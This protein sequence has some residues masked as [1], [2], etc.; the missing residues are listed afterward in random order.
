M[1]FGKSRCAT[2]KHLLLARPQPLA[3]PERTHITPDTPQRSTCL[4][5][6]VYQTTETILPPTPA[7]IGD[8]KDALLGNYDQTHMKRKRADSQALDEDSFGGLG[9]KL[10][11]FDGAAFWASI[12]DGFDR[13]QEDALLPMKDSICKLQLRHEQLNEKQTEQ[14]EQLS[15]IKEAVRK[16][17]QTLRT[18]TEKH[19][20]DI[21]ASTQTCTHRFQGQSQQVTN[22]STRQNTLAGTVDSHITQLPAL[23]E[24]STATATSVGTIRNTVNRETAKLHTQLR[25]HKCSVTNQVRQM[26]ELLKGQIAEDKKEFKEQVTKLSKEAKE[27][28]I[29]L[30]TMIKTSED[31][32]G[33]K[34]EK[35]DTDLAST[36]GRMD[37]K[38]AQSSPD[39]DALTANFSRYDD[40]LNYTTKEHLERYVLAQQNT[41]NLG[42]SQEALSKIVDGIQLS[43]ERVQQITDKFKTDITSYQDRHDVITSQHTRDISDLKSRLQPFEEKVAMKLHPPSPLAARFV[44]QSPAGLEAMS[45]ASGDSPGN[46]VSIITYLIERSA[47][48]DRYVKNHEKGLSNTNERF[49]SNKKRMADLHKKVTSLESSN[50]AIFAKHAASEQKIAEVERQHASDQETNKNRINELLHTMKVMAD[51]MGTM[52]KAQQAL[53]PNTA[54]TTNRNETSSCTKLEHLHQRVDAVEGQI[55]GNKTIADAKFVKSERLLEECTRFIRSGAA[56]TEELRQDMENRFETAISAT[57]EVLRRSH[58][59]S[60]QHQTAL[61]QQLDIGYNEA[62]NKLHEATAFTDKRVDETMAKILATEEVSLMALT[63]RVNDIESVQKASNE[64]HASTQQQVSKVQS[65]TLD[66]GQMKTLRSDL[67]ICVQ[68]LEDRID[69]MEAAQKPSPSMEQPSSWMEQPSSSTGE[70][71]KVLRYDVDTL[72]QNRQMKEIDYANMRRNF[73]SLSKSVQVCAKGAQLIALDTRLREYLKSVISDMLEDFAQQSLVANQ[74]CH[75]RM[76]GTKAIIDRVEQ[77]HNQLSARLPCALRH[78]SAVHLC[79][80]NPNNLIMPPPLPFQAFQLSTHTRK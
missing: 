2:P 30:E 36:L 70:E 1:E 23:E 76:E 77:A 53:V 52:Q 5:D 51:N 54:Q 57:E 71:F 62:V 14:E 6:N 78:P 38:I 65:L 24:S 21:A 69:N 25:N 29:A 64:S 33:R 72:M 44:P 47:R 61:L 56:N 59:T 60:K 75:D 79:T 20:S 42:K 22:L 26:E 68:A 18:D 16:D 32:Q 15:T 17:V 31:S 74:R 9:R 12:G 66:P 50:K 49:E 67:G 39:T 35:L 43:L 58:A 19:T 55:E 11:R 40:R 3:V 8:D 34:F 37:R 48:A 27:S 7:S 13:F 28:A 45:L 63:K 10:R 4:P 73:G 46:L 80:N 41:A